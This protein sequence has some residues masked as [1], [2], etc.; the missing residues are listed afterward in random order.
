MTKH[1]N[2]DQ[3]PIEEA[4][5]DMVNHELKSP[6]ATIKISAEIIQKKFSNIQ[7]PAFLESL[8]KINSRV[9]Y[10]AALINDYT[11]LVRIQ[12]K[13]NIFKYEVCYFDKLLE[14][15][16][17]DF[18][19][20]FKPTYFEKI[21]ILQEKIKVD[22][23]M[24]KKIVVSLVR[25][26][27]KISNNPIK[28]LISTRLKDG[29][30]IVNFRSCNKDLKLNKDFFEVNHLTKIQGKKWKEKNDLRIS[31][32][33]AKEIFNHCGGNF[34]VYYNDNWEAVC[35]FSIPVLV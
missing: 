33:L 26:L 16:T 34:S 3:P 10:L 11:D 14:E 8:Q 9:D 17:C 19:D 2:Q 7:E 12:S 13:K 35:C 25:Y 22:K 5:I 27:E 1:I 29:S 23:N 21:N 30:L 24:F 18:N 20:K 31:S 4:F 32:V 6:L 15:S 28:I